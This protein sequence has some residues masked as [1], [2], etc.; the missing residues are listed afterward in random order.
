MRMEYNV[1]V[2]LRLYL[3]GKYD[4]PLSSQD[5]YRQ[6]VQSA[7]EKSLDKAIA[8]LPTYFSSMY[9]EDTLER[10]DMASLFTEGY[11]RPRGY[12]LYRYVPDVELKELI[13][14]MQ[15]AEYPQKEIEAFATCFVKEIMHYEKVFRS[16]MPLLLFG[17]HISGVDI[18]IP[19]TKK[20]EKALSLIPDYVDFLT[21][22]DAINYFSE[23][24]VDLDATLY[25]LVQK[26]RESNYSQEAE[27]DFASAWFDAIEVQGKLSLMVMRLYLFGR[28]RYTGEVHKTVEILNPKWKNFEKALA[29]IPRYIVYMKKYVDPRWDDGVRLS[30]RRTLENYLVP[31]MCEFGYPDSEIKEFSAKWLDY[32]DSLEREL[33]VAADKY[34]ASLKGSNILV[35]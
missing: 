17:K 25:S 16:S 13:G 34:I 5:T 26:M 1:F 10:E 21:G 11:M 2:K 19:G 14:D 28:F 31:E 29:I 30:P 6:A 18:D 27:V 23:G 7:E 35:Q 9:A 22:A 32:L 20:L 4:G 15:K 33:T 8:L 3:F 24:F 12:A